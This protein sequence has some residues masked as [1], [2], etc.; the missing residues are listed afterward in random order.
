MLS[1]LLLLWR[2]RASGCQF[3]EKGYDSLE[4]TPSLGNGPWVMVSFHT[5]D[6]KV[7]GEGEDL[8]KKFKRNVHFKWILQTAP[9]LSKVKWEVHLFQVN[10]PLKLHLYTTCKSSLK[11]M[12][13]AELGLFG[14]FH[15][16]ELRQS[17]W[18]Q[19]SSQGQ[20]IC[21]FS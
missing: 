7:W 5:K 21:R 10:L 16:R 8:A 14:L 20:L 17:L 19:F 3:E 9:C 13:G 18:G 11:G 6:T 15:G 4:G 1:A 12:L 2:V